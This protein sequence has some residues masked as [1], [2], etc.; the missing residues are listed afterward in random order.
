MTR[1]YADFQKTDDHG[2]LVLST[3]GTRHDLERAGIELQE[4]LMLT[5][6]MDDADDEGNPDP[7]VAEGTVRFDDSIR[8]WVAEIDWDAVRNESQLN[9]SE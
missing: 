5:F 1:I 3:R 7:I 9:P 4:G 8:Q 6:Y 2:R